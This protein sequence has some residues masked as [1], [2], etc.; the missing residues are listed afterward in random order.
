MFVVTLLVG[1]YTVKYVYPSYTPPIY[2]SRPNDQSYACLDYTLITLRRRNRPF[3]GAGVRGTCRKD[4]GVG[5]GS[6]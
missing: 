2:V 5:T 6:L 4:N 3:I 1:T